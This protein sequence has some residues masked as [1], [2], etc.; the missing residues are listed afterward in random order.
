MSTN[1][2]ERGICGKVPG[3]DGDLRLARA[4]GGDRMSRVLNAAWVIRDRAESA[5]SPA[6]SDMPPKAEA[7]SEH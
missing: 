5:A 3:Q 2:P 7:N 4:E 1:C 6:M